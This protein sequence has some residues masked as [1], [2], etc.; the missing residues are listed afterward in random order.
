MIIKNLQK[1]HKKYAKMMQI[2][3]GKSGGGGCH[4]KGDQEGGGQG[5]YFVNSYHRI[6]KSCIL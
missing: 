4:A 6:H 3:K 2:I 5:K 1:I